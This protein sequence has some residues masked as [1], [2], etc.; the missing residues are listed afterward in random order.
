MNNPTTGHMTM[1]QA[2]IAFL[3]SQYVERD[4]LELPFFA[5][6]GLL[7]SVAYKPTNRLSV[8]TALFSTCCLCFLP[9]SVMR[10]RVEQ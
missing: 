10:Q 9:M 5:K 2:M 8:A 7:D 6:I 3:K 1:A 4:G